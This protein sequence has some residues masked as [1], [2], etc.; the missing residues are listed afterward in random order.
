MIGSATP[1]FVADV[2]IAGQLAEIGVM[3]LVFGVGLHF[4]L[5]D[6]L[7]VRKIELPGDI[8]QMTVATAL[9]TAVGAWWGWPVGG[10]IVFG[11]ALSVASYRTEAGLRRIVRTMPTPAPGRDAHVRTL[12]PV[13]GEPGRAGDPACGIMSR[14]LR[15]PMPP[16]FSTCV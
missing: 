14:G 8:V 16:T 4:S 9:G 6:L 11:L 3:L 10:A 2:E 1:G 5:G 15:T 7:S 13:A 12:Q